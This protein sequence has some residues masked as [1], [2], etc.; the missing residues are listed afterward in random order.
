MVA[1]IAKKRKKKKEKDC[2]ELGTYVS[3][4]GKRVLVVKSNIG[5][6]SK[7]VCLS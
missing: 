7:V 6:T 4:K 2:I 1:N 3:R 5:P